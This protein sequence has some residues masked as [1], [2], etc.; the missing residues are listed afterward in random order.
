MLNS[1]YY[2]L[3]I[4]GQE[5]LKW[6]KQVYS[7]HFTFSNETIREIVKNITFIVLEFDSIE[8]W[9]E[10]NI[11]IILSYNYYKIKEN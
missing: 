1:K 10:I 11:I 2:S 9:S 3:E 5:Y 8:I 4:N 6:T 7:L